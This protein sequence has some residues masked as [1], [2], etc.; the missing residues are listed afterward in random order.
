MVA[1]SDVM[2]ELAD[3]TGGVYFH[4][5]NDL[6]DG[7]RRLAAAPEFL[8]LLDFSPKSFKLNGTYHQLK[9]VVHPHGLTVQARLNI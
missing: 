3:G 9:V 4:N 1:N 6:Q 7:F 2:A 8:Y 5:S